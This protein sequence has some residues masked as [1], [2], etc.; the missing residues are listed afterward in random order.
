MNRNVLAVDTSSRSLSIAVRTARGRIFE[1]HFSNA[2]RHSE[3]IVTE[4]RLALHKVKLSSADLSDFLWGAGPGSFTGLRIGFSTLKAFALVFKNKK[5]FAASSL[6]L[7][8]LGCPSIQ[9]GKQLIVCVDARRERIYASSYRFENGEIKRSHKEV[10]VTIKTLLSWTNV[11]SILTG[12]ALEK[13][14]TLIREKAL[15]KIEFLDSK[16]WYPQAKTLFCLSEI[17]PKWLVPLSLRTMMPRYLRITEA[18]E[19][20]KNRLKTNVSKPNRAS[21]TRSACL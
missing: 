3:E 4:I 6:D 18:E 8:A 5:F 12:D 19:N 21:Q 7:I 1:I 10:L 11:E 17:K 20:R 9:T 14:G 2:L 16:Y 13:Y 15:N